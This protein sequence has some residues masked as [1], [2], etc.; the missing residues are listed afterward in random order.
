[1]TRSPQVAD[2][3]SAALLP[4]VRRIAVLRPA[5]VGDFVFALPA[6]HAFRQAYP[7]AEIVYIGKQWHADF[8]AGRP[9]PVDRVEVLPPCPGVGAAPDANADSQ[10]LQDFMARMQDAQFDLAVQLYGGGLYSNPFTRRLGARV[11]IGMKAS[12]A[13]PLDRW[14]GYEGLR[15]RRL[16]LL[17]VAALAGAATLCVGRE[18]QS[19]ERDRQE[20]AHAI[21]PDT[22][23]PLVLIQ[24]GASDSRR[25]WPLRRFAAVADA[26]AQAGALIAVNGTRQEAPVVRSVIENMRCPAIDLSGGLSLS[27][28]CGLLERAAL[29]VSNDTGPLHLALA[30]GTPCVGIYWLT[31]LI[32]SGPL[33]HDRHRAAVSVRVHCPVCGV[34]NLQ[35]RCPHDAS[36]VDGVP[37]E[38]VTALAMDL[39]RACQ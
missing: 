17:E 6:L 20:A 26:L 31:N 4:E 33:W 10:A 22:Q 18:L 14:L 15:N 9:G 27:G 30:I 24:P 5:A 29:L 11:A 25:C 36:F 23:R 37:V 35:A 1:M 28:L 3:I 16:Q 12:D 38:E 34:E 19:I 39:L 8:L 21:A 7:E 32:E 13:A 2:R